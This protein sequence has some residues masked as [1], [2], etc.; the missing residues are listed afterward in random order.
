MTFE[1]LDYFI[2]VVKFDTFL[3]AAETL[4]ITQSTLSKQIIKLEKELNLQLLDRSR[5]SA[6]LTEAGKMFYEEALELSRQYHQTLLRVK[7][8]Q[9]TSSLTLSIGTLPILSQYRLSSLL[10]NFADQN[11]QLHL[12]IDEVEE[13]ELMQG[14]LQDRYDLIIARQNM[15]DER[16]HHFYPLV[17][18]RLMAVLS[19][20][21]PLARSS[22]ISLEDIARE[23]MI[24]M[25]TH[26]SI[27]QLCIRM[28]HEADIQPH[29]L[30][31]ARMETIIG[32]VSVKEGI[33]LLPEGNLRLFQ[34]EHV[35]AIPLESSPDLT[36]GL[37]RKKRGSISPA[38]SRFLSAVNAE[39][40]AATSPVL[41]H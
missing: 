22:S 14:L 27:Y 10:K 19:E 32:A 3:E 17:H 38:A 6:T 15:V 9:E 39:F 21:H 13:Q 2:A 34:H 23:N 25:Q 30:R 12:M 33:S 18:D 24:L 4:H 31:T 11:P 29:I 16:K 26:T 36:V 35:T 5:R 41:E 28:F 8:F 1:Q 40:P 37:M 7:R 20:N